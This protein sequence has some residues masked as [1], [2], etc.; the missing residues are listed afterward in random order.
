MTAY[1]VDV[2]VSRM[3]ATQIPSLLT[4]GAPSIRLLRTPREDQHHALFSEF[5]LSTDIVPGNEKK[6]ASMLM[7]LQDLR[8]TFLAGSHSVPLPTHDTHAHHNQ[9]VPEGPSF[10]A[11][12]RPDGFK[13]WPGDEKNLR[14][15]LGLTYQLATLLWVVT[16]TL[17]SS[18]EEYLLRKLVVVKWNDKG[19]QGW[20]MGY[21][22]QVWCDDEQ[23]PPAEWVSAP[24][25]RQPCTTS[26]EDSDDCGEEGNTEVVMDERMPYSLAQ[27]N[28]TVYYST[29]ARTVHHMLSADTMV[30]WG[31]GEKGSW[32]L[33]QEK[34]LSNVPSGEA[35][36]PPISRPAVGRPHVSR[37]K[38][39]AGPTSGKPG[40]VFRPGERKSSRH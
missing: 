31:T 36:G 21:V 33:V 12:V 20:N 22:T 8:T 29:D 9:D 26:D 1:Q 4:S 6:F 32:G 3:L 37:L 16:P 39:H 35:P 17:M 7:A 25:V 13:E 40:K 15:I 2:A 23:P 34:G 5:R 38:P 10:T 27:V 11:S 28:A 14:Q 24:G 19:K 30:S 18:L